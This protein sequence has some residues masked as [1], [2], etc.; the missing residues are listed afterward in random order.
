MFG[1]GGECG[2]TLTAHPDVPLISFTGGTATGERI[3]QSVAPHH[4]K[5]SLELGG[6][7]ANIVFADCDFDAAVA[8][9]IPS[10]FTNQGQVCMCCSRILVQDT[11]YDRFVDALVERARQ[12]A[13]GDPRNPATRVRSV[14]LAHAPARVV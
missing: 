1:L 2:A 4:K 8:G 7:N 3:A 13:V 6:K 5:L 10:S 9:S 11:I 12:L 14:A